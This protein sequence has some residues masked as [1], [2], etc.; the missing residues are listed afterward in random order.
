MIFKQ[1]LKLDFA[2]V[3]AQKAGTTALHH[4]LSKH[5]KIIFGKVKELHYFDDDTM[6]DSKNREIN[7]RNLSKLFERFQCSKKG[8]LKGDATPITMFYPNAIERLGNHNPKIK[9]ICILRNPVDRAYSNW[10]MEVSRNREELSFEEAILQESK[11]VA[12]KETLRTFSYFERGLYC[13]QIRNLITSF[14]YENCLFL[15]H[16]DLLNDHNKTL[17]EVF[18]FLS[19]ESLRVEKQKIHESSSDQKMTLQTRSKLKELYFDEIQEIEKIL[20]WD[21]A[22]WIKN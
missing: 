3:G 4:F 9:V 8:V 16:E 13:R 14:G 1:N 22:T 10:K 7:N 18:N 19:L 5:P 15:K 17:D 20:N 6:F 11:R 12:D 21:L 2:I